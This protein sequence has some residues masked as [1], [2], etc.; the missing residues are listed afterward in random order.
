[1]RVVQL[2]TQDRG[3]PVDHAVEVAAELAARGHDSHLVGPP[4]AHAERAARLGVQ[5]H[6]VHVRTRHD[7]RGAARVAR[8]VA[9]LRPD[10]VHCQDRR[11]GVAGRMLGAAA[12]TGTV[13]TLHGVPDPLAP[14]VPGNLRIAAPSARSRM[15]NLLAERWLARAPRSLVV[16]PCE[17][18]ARYARD[19]VGIRADRV[20]AVHNGVAPRWLLPLDAPNEAAGHAPQ[21]DAPSPP[22]PL[23]VVW[24]GVMQPVKRV[25]D[26]VRAVA[27]LD[28]V[29]LVLVGDGPQRTRV[30]ALADSLAP[31][32]VHLVGFHDDPAP[33]LRTADVFVLSSAAEACPMALLQAMACGLPVIA[34]RVG[35]VAEIVRD[36]VDGL[37]F[38]AGDVDGL[39]A[40]LV[41]L[42]DDPALRD[43]LGASARNRVAE[44]FTL[45]GCVDRLLEAYA[46]V[47]R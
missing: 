16:T 30:A 3:G 31:D 32:R 14:L 13:Y 39:R 12:Q 20:R 27:P 19:H 38:A 33:L 6:V 4:G 36:G 5:V 44:R 28:D 40:E 15:D 2:I 1:M 24:V 34:S 29:E 47:A 21:E 10:V 46:E 35:G 23:R 25:P 26:L 18:V 17:A 9:A 45:G 11:A 37:L 8:T 41:R 7:V 22:R 43:R 42:A